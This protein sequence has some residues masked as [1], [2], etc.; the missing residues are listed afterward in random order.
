MVGTSKS[1]LEGQSDLM[2]SLIAK[3]NASKDHKGTALRKITYKFLGGLAETGNKH[4]QAGY[5]LIRVR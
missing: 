4:R 2:Y 1:L 3:V 5:W